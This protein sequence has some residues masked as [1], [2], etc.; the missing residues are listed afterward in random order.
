MVQVAACRRA[1]V[2]PV[3]HLFLE[4]SHY[5]QSLQLSDSPHP[6]LTASMARMLRGHSLCSDCRRALIRPT[7]P[8]AE[9]RCLRQRA[10]GVPIAEIARQ[11]NRTVA[12]LACKK[13]S[14]EKPGLTNS[15]EL[16]A[17][18][19]THGALGTTSLTGQR[20][21]RRRVRS[22]GGGPRWQLRGAARRSGPPESP[23]ERRPESCL[24]SCA[25][26]GHAGRRDPELPSES[27]IATEYRSAFPFMVCNCRFLRGRLCVGSGSYRMPRRGSQPMSSCIEA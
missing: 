8:V 1:V 9:S 21:V 19:A 6:T 22:H 26:S 14:H 24:A 18:G 12:P 5:C 25:P 2:C 10:A 13:R 7:P 15:Y 20:S 17:Y 3:S 27:G 16:Y 11:A 4:T 23:N